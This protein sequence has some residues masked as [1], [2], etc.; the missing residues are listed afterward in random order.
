MRDHLRLIVNTHTRSK[1]TLL[2]PI[3]L[4]HFRCL[5]LSDVW[6]CAQQ[7]V[8]V[9]Q[10][11]IIGIS[12]YPWLLIVLKILLARRACTLVI[13]TRP[14]INLHATGERAGVNFGHWLWTLNF[15]ANTT[16]GLYL[17]F[18]HGGR[19]LASDPSTFLFQGAIVIFNRQKNDHDGFVYRRAKWKLA[20]YSTYICTSLYT[21]YQPVSTILCH[22]LNDNYTQNIIR[23][24]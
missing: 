18:F 5:H 22:L 24:P 10:D 3:I 19:D 21:K 12:S 13:S 1:P 7:V 2:L 4:L 9:Y 16:L 15:R 11:Y 20:K 6:C 8:L 17:E 23:R 14:T